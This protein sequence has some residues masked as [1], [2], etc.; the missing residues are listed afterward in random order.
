MMVAADGIPGLSLNLD[1]LVEYPGIR[2]IRL[3]GFESIRYGPVCSEPLTDIQKRR[4]E[5]IDL[6]ARE[7]RLAPVQAALEIKQPKHRRC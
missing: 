7:V 2:M 4:L 6:I 3:P 1:Q 5:E